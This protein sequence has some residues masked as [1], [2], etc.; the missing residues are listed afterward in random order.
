MGTITYGEEANR[1]LVPETVT[2]ASLHAEAATYVKDYSLELDPKRDPAAFKMRYKTDEGV[3]ITLRADKCVACIVQEALSGAAFGSQ[4]PVLP[5]LT[6]HWPTEWH[7]SRSLEISNW[8]ATGSRHQ[9][10]TFCP[11]AVRG[12][13]GGL[14]CG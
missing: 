6:L 14:A 13:V 3:P 9:L 8:F 2:Y 7:H 4:K 5:T 11:N 10:T 12:W 1:F